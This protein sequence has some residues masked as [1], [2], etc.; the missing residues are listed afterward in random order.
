MNSG[1]KKIA[2][3]DDAGRGSIIGPLLIG[4]VLVDEQGL[5]DLSKIG[6]KDSKILTPNNRARL[7]SKIKEIAIKIEFSVVA[8]DLIDSYVLKGQKY[9]RLNYLEAIVMAKVVNALDP[10]IVY[11]DSSDVNP[12]RFRDDINSNLNRKIE[13]I[14]S[15]YADRLFPVVSAASIVAK[16]ER[17]SEIL[18]LGEK[19]GDLG[20]GYPADPKTIDFLKTWVSE[21]GSKPS[22]SRKSWKTWDKI[23]SKN[24]D[25]F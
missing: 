10:D 13:I 24:L 12:N 3:V 1:F 5:I 17:D 7:Y 14:S 16:C 18:K 11:V 6:V 19:H 25:D 2:G 15:H 21:H 4:G 22:F 9:K 8:P 20:S 23:I